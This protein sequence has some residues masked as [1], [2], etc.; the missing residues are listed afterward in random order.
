MNQ[1]YKN[2]LTLA[3]AMFVLLA[4]FSLWGGSPQ[5][6]REFTYSELLARLENGDVEEVHI[7]GQ[8][9]EGRFTNSESFKSRGPTEDQHFQALLREKGVRIAYAAADD[10][11]VWNSVLISWL[12]MLLFIGLWFLLFR[13]LQSGGGKAM[14][15]GKSRAKLLNESQQRITFADVAGIEEAKAEL[16]EIV[17]FLRDPE[18]VHAPRW[19]AI[20]KGVLLVGAPGDR[21]RP[22]WRER[23]R[24]RSRRSVLLHLRAP[25]SWRCSWAW[26]RAGCAISSRRARRMHPVSSSSTRSTPSVATAAPGSAGG[27]TSANRP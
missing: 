24:R 7:R 22:C 1:L 10:S 13:Q 15:F 8:Q 5:E 25:T 19:D 21:A 14:S 4:I 26:V 9:I 3:M 23:H 11:G 18:E 6:T 17:S 27:T 16:E 20:P 12:P 2:L